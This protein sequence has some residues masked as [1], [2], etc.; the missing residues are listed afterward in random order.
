MFL[1][2]QGPIDRKFHGHGK[3]YGFVLYE[4]IFKQRSSFWNTQTSGLWKKIKENSM[5]T[6]H[7]K[8]VMF[9]GNT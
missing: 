4:Y 5:S 7:R 2:S 6:V 9:M 1:K 3:N 8:Y